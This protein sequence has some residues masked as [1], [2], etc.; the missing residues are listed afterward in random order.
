VI[1]TAS[2]PRCWRGS[3]ES[4]LQSGAEVG[5][6]TPSRRPTPSL[7]P[8]VGRRLR[9]VEAATVDLGPRG[10]DP[11][12]H[13]RGGDGR[14]RPARSLATHVELGTFPV[15]HGDDARQLSLHPSPPPH[16][17]VASHVFGLFTGIGAFL[18]SVLN[19]SLVFAGTADVNPAMLFVSGPSDPRLAQ[20]QG[21]TGSTAALLAVGPA[22]TGP[23]SSPLLQPPPPPLA[24]L[25]VR[26]LRAEAGTLRPCRE[27]PRGE[28]VTLAWTRLRSRSAGKGGVDASANTP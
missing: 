13:R 3:Q 22:G 23:S 15:G 25:A 27:S 10:V 17:R 5:R 14:P 24:L 26:D 20:R 19:V 28:P 9:H 11:E 21:G 4:F 2:W 18:G 1:P 6:R 7:S 12:E 8:S 16:V